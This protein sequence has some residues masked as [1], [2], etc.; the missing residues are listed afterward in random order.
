[1]AVTLYAFLISALDGAGT[2]RSGG[3]FGMDMF[4]ERK[5]PSIRVASCY[6]L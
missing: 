5:N 3:L 4:A 1:M 2:S 6:L